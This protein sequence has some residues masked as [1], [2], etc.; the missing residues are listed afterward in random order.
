VRTIFRVSDYLLTLL[1]LSFPIQT[2]IYLLSNHTYLHF[3][4]VETAAALP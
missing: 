2:S 3:T 4:H 1:A